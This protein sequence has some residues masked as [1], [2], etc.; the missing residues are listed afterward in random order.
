MKDTLKTL[1]L[2]QISR[3]VFVFVYLALLFYVGNIAGNSL[4]PPKNSVKIEVIE[5]EINPGQSLYE[6][7]SSDFSANQTLS[8]ER[9]LS[10]VFNASRTR[11]GDKYCVYHSTSGSILKF[12]YEPSPLLN[13]VVKRTSGGFVASKG[14]PEYDK[15][16]VGVKGRIS[17]SLWQGMADAGL[18]SNMIMN[19]ANIFQW[20]VDFLTEVRP[21]DE[22]FMVFER[23]YRNGEPVENGSILAAHYAGRRN[24]SAVRFEDG[25]R[26][27]F[28][29]FS[30][31]SLRKQFLRAPLNYKRISSGFSYARKHPITREVRPHFA[32][33][34]AAPTGT[35]ISS[36]G[37]GRVTYVGWR[38][39]WGKTVRVRHNSVYTTQYA[40]LSRYASGIRVN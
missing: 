28:Y 19:F 7:L 25:D 31:S 26:I 2:K 17:S 35:P 20:Q 32:I 12:I 15:K 16:T 10:D 34:Y 13:Y 21:D 6:V 39:G 36:I 29:D 33:D 38:G 8:L 40:H 5:G 37:S 14:E 3:T 23:Y 4:F 1:L 18:N 22:F 30:G 24:F 9:A 11:P 27:D